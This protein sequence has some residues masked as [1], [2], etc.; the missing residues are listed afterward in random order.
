LDVFFWFGAQFSEQRKTL[1]CGGQPIYNSL[2]FQGIRYMLGRICNEPGNQRERKRG[3]RLA[4]FIINKLGR[5]KN[6][7][8]CNRKRNKK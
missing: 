2:K 1:F 4:F 5:R 7:C 3:R 6:L 8:L